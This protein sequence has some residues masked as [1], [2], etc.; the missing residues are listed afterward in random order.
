MFAARNAGL[1]LDSGDYVSL[2]IQ[3]STARKCVQ[4]GLE[5]VSAV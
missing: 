4:S 1:A 2:C 3:M 5:S